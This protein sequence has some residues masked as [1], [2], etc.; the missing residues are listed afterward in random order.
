MLNEEQAKQ[1][2]SQLLEQIKKL[3]PDQQK[4]L[5]K[6]ISDM[7]PEE[8]E[9]FLIQNNLMKPGNEPETKGKA[10]EECV[11]CSILQGKI[12]SY[13]LEENKTAIAILEINP[14][15]PGHSIIISKQHGKLSNSAFSLANKLGKR[16]KRKL[17]ADDIKIE[18][19]TMF[20][21]HMINI[22]PLYKDKKL[23]KRKAE[24]KELIL[25]QEKLKV[26]PREKKQKTTVKPVTS[27]PKWNKMRIP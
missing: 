17:K 5:E 9:Q 20:G 25:L 11:F 3:P 2:K 6:E 27:L 23:E 14:L 10:K 7:N 26:K 22:I 8:L 15:S 1:I 18:N 16:I 24:E 21:H 13:K 12:P 19:A 4:E